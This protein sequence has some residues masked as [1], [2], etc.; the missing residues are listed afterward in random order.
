MAVHVPRKALVLAA[1]AALL[2]GGMAARNGFADDDPFGPAKKPPP[3]PAVPKATVLESLAPYLAHEDWL[4]RALAAR[5]L[6][7]RAEDGVVAALSKTLVRE[8]DARVE[9]FVLEAL[10]GRPREDLLVEGGPDLAEVVVALAT[11]PHPV[12][13]ERALALARRLPPI[14]L[15]D[16]ALAVRAWWERAKEAYALERDEAIARRKAEKEKP[17]PGRVPMAPGETVTT[18]AAGAAPR[19]GQIERVRREGLDLMICLDE[20]GSME[21]V[22]DA[23]K[24]TIADL[25][26]RIRVLAPKFRVGLITYTDDAFLRVPLTG[27]E[28]VLRKAFRKVRAAGGGDMEEGVDKAIAMAAGQKFSGWYGKA[29]RVIV[30]VGD[31]P[32]HEEDVDPLLRLISSVRRDPLYEVPLRIDTIS[33]NLTGDADPDGFVHHFKAIAATGRG[34]AVRLDAYAGL[35]LEIVASTFGPE[36]RP[37]IKALAEDLEALDKAAIPPGNR[38]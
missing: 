31:A 25:V 17:P 5:E 3:A 16:D 18:D 21:P 27:D 35:A 8:T 6:R 24:A 26:R 12:V 11:H 38:K 7:K 32:P 34:T 20:T 37:A 10:A 30:V 15:P 19:Y 33:T 2:A 13:R 22:I 4:C 36:W 1:A 28:E 9:A 14:A 23:A 29:T